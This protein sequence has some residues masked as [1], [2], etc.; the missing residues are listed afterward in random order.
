[1]S[2]GERIKEARANAKMTQAELANKIGTSYVVISQYENG[3]R[4][5]KLETLQKIAC[6][7]GVNVNTLLEFGEPV[8][9]SEEN[10]QDELEYW[11]RVL[12]SQ[13]N[14][15]NKVGLRKAVDIVIDLAKIP[16]YQD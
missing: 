13:S 15:L 9:S 14:K 8:D 11:R 2:V 5:P 10:K 12:A 3:K 16:E 7:L 4:N 6:T 1:M